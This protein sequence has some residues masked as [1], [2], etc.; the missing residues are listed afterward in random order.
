MKEDSDTFT[1]T[2]STL[3]M[4]V[5]AVTRALEWLETQIFARVCFLG[6]CE[7]AQNNQRGAGFIS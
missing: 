6:D 5:T 2:T 3:T 1:M 7:H 4:E